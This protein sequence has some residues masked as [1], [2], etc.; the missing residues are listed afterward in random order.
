VKSVI[1]LKKIF[2][3]FTIIPKKGFYHQSGQ[4]KSKSNFSR[5]VIN[6]Q[7]HFWVKGISIVEIFYRIKQEFKRKAGGG[8]KRWLIKKG[9]LAYDMEGQMASF[10]ICSPMLEPSFFVDSV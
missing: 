2:R 1:D 4:F 3:V 7:K 8:D 10:T 5:I 6:Q 9:L